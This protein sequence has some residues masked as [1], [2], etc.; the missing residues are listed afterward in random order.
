MGGG[1]DISH[2][3]TQFH[4]ENSIHHQTS[5]TRTPQQNR[6]AERRNQ[7]ILEIVRAS[8]FDINVPRNF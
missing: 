5:C 3:M 8:I 6:L 1:G 7:N 2:E 4:H